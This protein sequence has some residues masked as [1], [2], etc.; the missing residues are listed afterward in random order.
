MLLDPGDDVRVS[1]GLLE[2]HDPAGG[3]VVA[4]PTPGMSSPAATA[5]DVLAALGRSVRRLGAEWLVGLDPA[6]RAVEAWLLTDEIEDLVVL[7]ADRLS[8]AGWDWLLQVCR[9]TGVRLLL[10][11]HV[12]AV[13]AALA[14]V[15]EDVGQHVG[16]LGG[17]VDHHRIDAA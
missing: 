16:Q 15:L 13:P 11:C 12:H 6:G 3:L 8:A 17:T 1:V 9:R 5:H 2:R 10:V 7:R 14:A 4:H